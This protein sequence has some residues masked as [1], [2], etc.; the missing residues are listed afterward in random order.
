MKIPDKNKEYIPPGSYCYVVLSINK[1]YLQK[2]LTCP[3]WEGM[4][5]KPE[6]QFGYCNWLNMGD[7]QD[8]GTLL[9]WDRCKECGIKDGWDEDYCETD[10]MQSP[11]YYED[12]IKW[13]EKM[14]N[15]I[16]DDDI[17]YKKE[18]EKWLNNIKMIK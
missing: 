17:E 13:G 7:W 5:D 15:L 2:T 3:Y 18:I 4:I 8:D 11:K 1:R 14:L 6:H 9:L 12:L 16:D 10:G